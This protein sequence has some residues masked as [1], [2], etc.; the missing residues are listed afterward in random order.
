MLIADKKKTPARAATRCAGVRDNEVSMY[1]KVIK[2][3]QL[4][5]TGEYEEEFVAGDGD[6]TLVVQ[7]YSEELISVSARQGESFIRLLISRERR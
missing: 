5:L 2:R 4:L 1:Q 7:E 6:G 3:K